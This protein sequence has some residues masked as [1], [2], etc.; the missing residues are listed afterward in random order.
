MPMPATAWCGI[1]SLTVGA[2]IL[3]ESSLLS[4][5]SSLL[6]VNVIAWARKLHSHY[7]DPA[8][9]PGFTAETVSFPGGRFQGGCLTDQNSLLRTSEVEAQNP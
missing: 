3:T 9:G 1:V 5:S 8:V 7:G 6:L 2:G 4:G